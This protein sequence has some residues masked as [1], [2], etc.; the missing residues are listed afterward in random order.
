[1][2]KKEKRQSAEV[3]IQRVEAVEEFIFGLPKMKVTLNHLGSYKMKAVG[4]ENLKNLSVKW[5]CIAG[6]V[7]TMPQF[8]AWEKVHCGSRPNSSC[9]INRT[10]WWLGLEEYSGL[11]FGTDAP[12]GTHWEEALSRLSKILAKY[13]GIKAEGRKPSL[14][15]V[16]MA[17]C[18]KQERLVAI[19]EEVCV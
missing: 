17:I 5:A 11:A 15:E 14:K 13:R 16:S 9:V 8:R 7:S 4:Y 2:L 12:N 3:Y 1:M 19:L 10:E 18:S 6:W